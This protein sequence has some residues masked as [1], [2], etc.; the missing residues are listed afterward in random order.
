MGHWLVLMKDSEKVSVLMELLL[1][2]RSALRKVQMKAATMVH[3]PAY[4]LV[5]MMV[6]L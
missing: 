3:L 6:L 2:Y 1:G 5:S 4:C